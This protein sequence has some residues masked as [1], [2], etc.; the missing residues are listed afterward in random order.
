MGNTIK[1]AG[2]LLIIAG[3]S[4]YGWYNHVQKEKAKEKAQAEIK[5]EIIEIDAGISRLKERETELSVRQEQAEKER[6]EAEKQ[7]AAQTV[8]LEKARSGLR[9]TDDGK[10]E[11]DSISDRERATKQDISN[12]RD[13]LSALKQQQEKLNCHYKCMGNEV[14]PRREIE[15][16]R[17]AGRKINKRD[18]ENLQNWGENIIDGRQIWSWR[19]K[20]HN[21]C[22]EQR[23]AFI[24]YRNQAARLDSEA[25]Q[26]LSSIEE[27]EASLKMLA[28]DRNDL[29]KQQKKQQELAQIQQEQYAR[30]EKKLSDLDRQ[31]RRFRENCSEVE[32]QRSDLES[33]LKKLAGRKTDLEQKLTEN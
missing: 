16:D 18:L 14:D 22:F 12:H 10:T 19:C 4:G 7:V 21:F 31:A 32:E 23:I 25:K 6:I 9:K 29:E 27:L 8:L 28:R 13:Q 33:D 24:D 3:V 26:N 11:D 2:L 5:A 1:L 20:K 17:K 30:L 15:R